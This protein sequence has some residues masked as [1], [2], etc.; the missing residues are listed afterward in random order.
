MRSLID[1][2]VEVVSI[3]VT[4]VNDA[5]VANPD[6]YTIAEDNTLNVAGPGILANDTDVDG[7][8]LSALLVSGPAHGTLTLNEIGRASC[9]ERVK[10]SVVAGSLNKTNDGT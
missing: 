1:S 5:P 4:P 3:T 7:N 8:S 6:S 2:N 10:I 9:R